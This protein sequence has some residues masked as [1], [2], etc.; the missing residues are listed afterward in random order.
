VDTNWK[1]KVKLSLFADDMIVCIR[2]LK[3]YQRTLKLTNT[4]KQKSVAFLN[5]NDKWIEKEINET[6]H[7]TVAAN[8]I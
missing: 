5:T 6:T 4:Y 7:F 8:D 1:G 3:F 2:N